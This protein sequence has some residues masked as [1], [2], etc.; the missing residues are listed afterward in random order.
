MMDSSQID[1]LNCSMPNSFYWLNPLPA[2]CLKVTKVF[3]TSPL[4]CKPKLN[5]IVSPYPSLSNYL[6]PFQQQLSRESTE[7]WIFKSNE[8]NNNADK[9]MTSLKIN[10]ELST[11]TK[12]EVRMY[13]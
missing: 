1:H 7:L 2:F 4:S 6:F 12:Q 9:T 11:F 8:Y 10:Q 3:N 5:L 13:S